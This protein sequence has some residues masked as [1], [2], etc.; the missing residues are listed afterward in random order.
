ME[1]DYDRSKEDAVC[2]H[3]IFG[4]LDQCVDEANT[5][6]CT[7]DWTEAHTKKQQLDKLIDAYEIVE[8]VRVGTQ[9]AVAVKSCL[10]RNWVGFLAALATITA[11][12]VAYRKRHRPPEKR[13]RGQ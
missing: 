12:V 4:Q 2:M 13:K 10:E 8:F 7:G 3:D 11:I 1:Y 6:K 5:A 9:T